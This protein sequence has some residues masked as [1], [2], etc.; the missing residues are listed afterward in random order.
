MEVW[1]LEA[2]GAAYTLQKMLTVRS[3]MTLT[4]VLRCTRTSWM[5]TTAWNL[6]CQNRSTYC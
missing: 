2:Y 3:R 4:A 5:A 1:A 6:A